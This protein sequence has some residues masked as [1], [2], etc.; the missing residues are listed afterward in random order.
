[1]KN[2]S[3][4]IAICPQCDS[5]VRFKKPAQ[6]GQTMS[7]RNCSSQLQVI[8]TTPIELDW[9]SEVDH[10]E[11]DNKKVSKQQWRGMRQQK[12]KFQELEGE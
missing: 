8:T 2:K 7:C 11:R 4:K 10:A 1:M 3:K 5:E 12:L 6:V 9:A